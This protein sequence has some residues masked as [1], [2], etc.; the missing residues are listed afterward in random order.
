MVPISLE[1]QRPGVKNGDRSVENKRRD[2]QMS[3]PER[4]KRIAVIGE[5]VYGCRSRSLRALPAGVSHVIHNYSPSTEHLET[6][7]KGIRGE[8]TPGQ[9]EMHI[10]YFTCKL[11]FSQQK[12]YG[13]YGRG[14]DQSLLQVEKGPGERMTS[15]QEFG[16]NIG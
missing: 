2:D 12:T 3:G 10:V 7:G 5:A 4:Q 16:G 15:P 6:K 13:C 11:R 8:L 1:Y 14:I 9:L